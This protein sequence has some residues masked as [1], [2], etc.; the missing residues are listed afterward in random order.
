MTHMTAKARDGHFKDHYECSG[1]EGPKPHKREGAES[2]S[3]E[4]GRKATK[5]KD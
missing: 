4:L 3:K 2:W 5:S 1:R